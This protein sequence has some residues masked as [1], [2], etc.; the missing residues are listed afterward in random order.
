MQFNLPLPPP[1]EGT[2]EGPINSQFAVAFD[3]LFFEANTTNNHDYVI[4]MIQF[5]MIILRNQIADGSCII[6]IDN[7][8]QKSILKKLKWWCVLLTYI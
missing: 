5:A 4:S 3:F 2:T 6:K 1:F 8:F 7:L